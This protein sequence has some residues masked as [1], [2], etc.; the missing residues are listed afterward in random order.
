MHATKNVRAIFHYASCLNFFGGLKQVYLV[1]FSLQFCLHLFFQ[2]HLCLNKLLSNRKRREKV[3][4]ICQKT[5]YVNFHLNKN[6]SVRLFPTLFVFKLV[7]PMKSLH[8]CSTSVAINITLKMI[9]LD[10]SGI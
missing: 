4:S 9:S 6:P 8:I 7:D 1:N 10:F 3:F 5:L 2:T